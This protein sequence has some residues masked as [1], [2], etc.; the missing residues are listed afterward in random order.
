[1]TNFRP[2]SIPYKRIGLFDSGVG[3]LSVLRQLAASLPAVDF[4]YLGD[5]ARLPYGNRSQKEIAGFVAEIVGFLT[6]FRLDAVVMACN[7]SAALA[8][9]VAVKY[10]ARAG[11]EVCNLIEPTAQYLSRSGLKRVGILATKATVE[12]RAFTKALEDVNFA[13]KVFAVAC[14]ALVP[15][16]ESGRLGESEIEGALEAALEEY[17]PKVAGAEAIVLGCTH[18][19]FIADRIEGLVQ[20]KLKASFPRP[21]AILDPAVILSRRIANIA[22]FADPLAGDL[23]IAQAPDMVASPSAGFSAGRI[24]IFT[25]GNAQDFCHTAKV[26]LGRDLGAVKE[27]SVSFLVEAE[28]GRLAGRQSQG[29]NAAA[30]PIQVTVPKISF[31]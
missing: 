18:F 29:K 3:G 20:G 25:T 4:V 27:V 22:T 30:V 21:A 12:S 8:Q 13:G 31:A 23:N 9:D 10:A 26:C 15:L 14:P 6:E 17:L 5:T 2:A 1:M 28:S 24:E 16:I 19:P 7:T 11:F